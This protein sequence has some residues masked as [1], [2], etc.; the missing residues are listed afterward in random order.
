MPVV[1]LVSKLTVRGSRIE[2]EPNRSALGS[3]LKEPFWVE[4]DPDVDVAAWP[5]AWQLAPFVL[6][7]APIVWATGVAV[8]VDELDSRLDSSLG[9][10]RT[11]FSRD[12]FPQVE[13]SGTLSGKTIAS[14][15]APRGSAVAGVL[16]SGG[17][18][19]VATSFRHLDERQRLVTI[20]GADV[21]NADSVGWDQVAAHTRAYAAEYGHDVSFISSNMRTFYDAWTLDNLHAAIPDWWGYVQH[22]MGLVGLA[23]PLL[24]SYG[25]TRLYIASSHTSSFSEP[26]GSSPQLDESIRLGALS[27]VHDGYDAGRQAKIREILATT[28]ARGIEVPPLRV[29]YSNPDGGGANCGKCEKCLRTVAGVMIE[30]GDLAKIGFEREPGFYQELIRRKFRRHT[31][32]SGKNPAWM[33][34]D[35]QTRARELLAA[36]PDAVD[37]S[38][39]DLCRW[40]DGFDFDA[41]ARR[42][43]YVRRG[44]RFLQRVLR[45]NPNLFALARRAAIRLEDR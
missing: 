15:A 6:N 31:M 38:V 27:V 20:W 9:D 41:Y 32:P 24:L 3:R 30:G 29:C 13:W 25:S 18:D 11:L 35:I 4:Y 5:V 37:G 39:T 10:L 2:V 19:S 44:R 23:A 36:G 33:W 34:R 8:E 12:L 42:Y 22:G 28:R 14:T 21:S 45:R 1:D 40:L 16:F 43:A 7:V 17:L 26:W